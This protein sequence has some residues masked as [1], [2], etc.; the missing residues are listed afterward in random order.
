MEIDGVNYIIPTDAKLARDFDLDDEALSL[1]RVLRSIEPARRLR[2]VILDAC[3]DNPFTKAMRRSVASR[4]V[5]RGLAKI[6]PT[7]SNTLVAFAAKAGSVALDG[8]GQNSPFTSS[9]SGA[10]RMWLAVDQNDATS[11]A[12][13]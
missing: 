9:E 10:D 5:S 11:S 6:E 7:A 3:R 8:D 13:E 2:L 12:W 1:D 4:A